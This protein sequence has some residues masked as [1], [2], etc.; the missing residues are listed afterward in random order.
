MIVYGDRERK[1]TLA[2]L[3]GSLRDL[4][5][6]AAEAAPERQGEACTRLLIESGCLAQALLDLE[7]ARRGADHGGPLERD[8]LQLCRVS[9]R[10]LLCSLGLRQPDAGWHEA[11]AR[12]LRAVARVPGS[13][14][15][16]L[17][18]PEGYAHYGLY[19]E[20]YAWAAHACAKRTEAPSPRWCVIGVRSIGTSLGAVVS[21]VLEAET[22]CTVRPEGHPYAR[23]VRIGDALAA[24]LLHHR[25]SAHYAIVDEGPGRS[26]SSF[27]AVHRWLVSRD[28]DPA[29]ISFFPSH[30]GEPGEYGD[31]TFRATYAAARR[32]HVG[33]EAGVLA[34]SPAE[35]A[36]WFG[37]ELSGRAEGAARDLSGGRWRPLLY[38]S[39]HGYPPAHVCGEARKFLVSSAQQHWLLKQIGLGE[40]AAT[41]MRQKQFLGELGLCPAQYAAQHGFVLSRWYA[42]G[43]PLDS[44]SAERALCLRTLGTYVTTLARHFRVPPGAGAGPR[45][46]LVMARTNTRALLGT[47]EPHDEQFAQLEQRLPQLEACHLPVVTDN[48]LDLYEW[49]YL[50]EG[51]IFKCDAVEHSRAHDLVGCQDPAWDLAGAQVEFDLNEAELECLLA[52]LYDAT[53]LAP[54]RQKLRF[55]AL[56][57]LAFRAGQAHVAHQ[58]MLGQWPDDASRMAK[59]RD[60]YVAQLSARL[61]GPRISPAALALPAGQ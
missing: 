26:G 23:E 18:E 11:F 20:Q 48:K 43:K 61:T 30:A 9:A 34:S 10:A 5:V 59:R 49:I 27:A 21:E 33:F 58:S 22:F 1:L 36:R 25:A 52:Q 50:P 37:E 13:T 47:A 56:A 55:Y 16:V 12:R 31:A 54:S 42:K 32:E 45:E 17:R 60:F 4:C 41:C 51:R 8:C 29:H 44:C 2:T 7:H 40:N 3:L 14:P 15:L 35:I 24:A 39:E 6:A 53:R 38:A 57:Y 19:P 28:V 46:L